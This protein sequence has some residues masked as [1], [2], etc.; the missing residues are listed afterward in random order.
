MLLQLLTLLAVVAPYAIADVEFTS[1]S[2]GQTLQGGSTIKVAWKDS[3]TAPPI[4]DLQS[5]Q[6]FLCAGGNDA[7]SIVRACENRMRIKHHTCALML[8]GSLRCRHSWPL[9]PRL[10]TSIPAMTLQEQS[11]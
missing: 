11:P 4:S 3:G 6:L 7:N 1:P 9:S 2:A 5:Y 8:M 10:E